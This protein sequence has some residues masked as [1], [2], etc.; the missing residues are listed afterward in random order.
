MAIGTAGY[1]AALCVDAL[2]KQGLT[3]DSGEILV[4][5]AGGGVGSIA[6]ALLAARG[7][8]VAAATGRPRES[9]YLRSL[10]AQE[11][12]ERETLSTPGKP[13]A[14]ARWAGAIDTVGSTTLANVCAAMAYR[15]VVAACGLAQGMDFP[16]T[17]APFILRGVTLVGIDSVYAPLPDREAAWKRLGRDLDPRL[18]DNIAGTI[19]LADA[20]ARAPELLAGRVRG[21]LVVDVNR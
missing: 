17:V 3:P 21:R 6:V 13:L 18:L 11:I 9:E 20:I 10:G 14:K 2:E 12:I 5:G 7:Y 16:A 4:T 8:R 15:G 1:T 19:G